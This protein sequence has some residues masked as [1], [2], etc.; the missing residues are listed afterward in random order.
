MTWS[1]ILFNNLTFHTLHNF[2]RIGRIGYELL[3]IFIRF[4]LK[5]LSTCNPASATSTRFTCLLAGRL[6]LYT[7]SGFRF[8]YRSV[9]QQNPCFTRILYVTCADRENRTPVSSLARTCSTT[10]PYPQ[11]HI[12]HGHESL[13][14]LFHF[15]CL[16]AG[17]LIKYKV[18]ATPPR[19]S[20]GDMA[21]AT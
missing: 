10:K 7:A 17:R 9:S 6:V 14:I 3:S 16:P 19:L 8:S 13:S 4:A 11:I 5:I 12:L 15:A 1:V 2:V 21:A 18:F 20:Q